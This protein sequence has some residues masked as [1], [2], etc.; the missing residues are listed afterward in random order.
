MPSTGREATVP[1]IGREALVTGHLQSE[2]LRH[3]PGV[4]FGRLQARSDTHGRRQD[5]GRG[6]PP[7]G[8][9]PADHPVCRRRWHRSRHLAGHT[10]RCRRVC[11]ALLS[12]RT[13]DR[14]DGDLCRRKSQYEN[15]RVDPGRDL[16]GISGVQSGH[17]GSAHHA[18]RRGD[19]L[20]ERVVAASSRPL[21]LHPSSPAGSRASPLP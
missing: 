9:G 12:G 18:G 4:V 2:H 7:R 19:S 17:Q 3:R 1:S 5:H 13:P 14:M 16:R 21:L 10:G 6:R 8:T 15:R 20:P 11:R